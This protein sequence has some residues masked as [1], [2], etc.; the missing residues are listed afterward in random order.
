M[1][2]LKS[3]LFVDELNKNIESINLEEIDTSLKGY[4]LSK[5]TLGSDGYPTLINE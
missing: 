3:Q 2:Y 4:T 5:W 1:D